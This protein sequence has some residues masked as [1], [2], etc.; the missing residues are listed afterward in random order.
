M[1]KLNDVRR[2][3]VEL[4]TRCNARCPMC[5]RNYRGYEYNSG[6][7]VCDMSFKDFAHIFTPAVLASIMQSDPPIN[8][9]VPVNYNFQGVVFNGNLGDFSSAKD[10]V[11]I[12]QY[13]VQ[14]NVHVQINTNG[15]TRSPAWWSRLALPGVTVGFALDGLEDTHHLY[16][17]DTDWHKIIENAQAFIQAGGTAIWRFVP[18]EHNQHQEQACKELAATLGFSRFEN[19]GDG[20]SA[21][22]V[23][24]R[25]GEFSHQI[26]FD[27]RPKESIPRIKELLLG[28]LTWFDPATV[29]VAADVTPLKLNCI[30]KMNREIYIAADGSVYPCC[31]LGFYPGQMSHPGNS[32]LAPL[33]HENNALEYD[34]EHC[35]DWFAAVEETWKAESIAAGRLY[36]CVSSCGR[37]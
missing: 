22:P 29:T 35:L 10:G 5:V 37:L 32:Q 21:T 27:S 9:R 25:A 16:R 2:V 4:T 13:L 26:G 8:G 18:F 1:L 14:H 15:S 19:I 7:P 31:Y 6:Y 33:V 12:V 30:H 23:F 24:T 36:Q 28:H 17:Q 34:L 3:H 11:E 20:R